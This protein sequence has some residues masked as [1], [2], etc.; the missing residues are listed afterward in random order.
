MA[1]Q[2]GIRVALE[3]FPW[4][5]VNDLQCCWDLVSQASDSLAILVD[6]LHFNRSHSSLE[7]LK[8]IPADRLPF[9]Q[10]C[11][12]PVQP[13]YTF[14]ELIYAGRDERLAP[15]SGEIPLTEIV[16]ALPA[17]TPISLEVPQLKKTAEL[18]EKAV[19]TELFKN[20][21]QFFER[22]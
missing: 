10:L 12:A 1:Q 13:S 22:L 19:L 16:N 17:G 20:S 9:A 6:S 14:D 2:R 3:F 5:P 15:G 8:T 11:D 7:L 18:G 4:T 21:Q